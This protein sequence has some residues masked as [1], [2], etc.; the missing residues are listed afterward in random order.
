[1]QSH[2]ALMENTLTFNTDN[3]GYLINRWATDSH[4]SHV[5]STARKNV[6]QENALNGTVSFSGLI[7]T[8]ANHRTEI[9]ITVESGKVHRGIIQETFTDGLLLHQ[10]NTERVT[11]TKFDAIRSISHRT[12]ARQ[13]RYA[14]LNESRPQRSRSVLAFFATHA[15]MESYVTIDWRSGQASVEIEL[16]D[17]G[18]D[19]LVSRETGAHP[20]EINFIRNDTYEAVHIP[21]INPYQW[22]THAK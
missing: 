22:A 21:N 19:F 4:I 12:Q 1:M 18:D 13:I 8:W 2:A 15:P 20:R 6:A 17:V 14:D 3:F 5:I 10:N 16:L 11:V 9:S 7:K